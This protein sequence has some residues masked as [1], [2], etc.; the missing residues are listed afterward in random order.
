[1]GD[2]DCLFL[3]V[4]VPRGLDI[5]NR[6]PVMVWIHGGGYMVGSGRSYIH[7]PLA[8]FGDV[9]TVSINYRVGPLGFL[10]SDTGMACHLLFC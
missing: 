2:E 1:M 8:M 9:I 7:T 10:A 3:D 6:K 4:T 5:N